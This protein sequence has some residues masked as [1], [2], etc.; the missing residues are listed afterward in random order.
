MSGDSHRSYSTTAFYVPNK[1]REN[2]NVLITATVRRVLFTP[3]QSG[4]LIATS[5]EFE[6][7]GKVYEVNAK[8]EIIVSA[9]TLGSP[10]IL[11]L[12]GIGRRDVLEKA[13]IPLKLELPGVGENVQEHIMS[14][15]SYDPSKP[16]RRYSTLCM[17]VNYLW[18]RGTIHS[19][20]SDPKKMPEI[21]PHYFERDMVEELNPGPEVESDEQLTKWI[22]ETFSTVWHTSSFCSMLPKDKGGDVDNNLKVYGITNL[23]VVN[24]SVVPLHVGTHTQ[25]TVYGIAEQ[26]ADII[27]GKFEAAV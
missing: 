4:N 16:G 13:G 22:R 12:S 11:N 27:K 7:G 25:S 3:E 17:A 2:L 24:F 23:R 8:Q 20:S 5:V 18:S 21:D 10:H 15:L 6:H 9:G 19:T 1:D 26:A 14:Q